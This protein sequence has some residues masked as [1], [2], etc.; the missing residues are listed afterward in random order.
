VQLPAEMK[1]SMNKK[2]RL[3]YETLENMFRKS[4]NQELYKRKVESVR[5]QVQF[6]KRQ[7]GSIYKPVKLIQYLQDENSFARCASLKKLRDFKEKADKPVH[8]EF[9][10]NKSKPY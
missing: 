9:V 4:N 5:L 1:R 10:V 2:L 6:Q 7:I 8:A 3:E